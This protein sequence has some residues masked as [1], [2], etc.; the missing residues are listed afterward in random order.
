MCMLMCVGTEM[1]EGERW[2]AHVSWRVRALS[3][4]SIPKK[5]TYEREAK[6]TKETYERE[7]KETYCS[8]KRVN[9]VWGAFVLCVVVGYSRDKRDLR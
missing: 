9:V 7:A 6:E 4:G 1:C 2:G 8:G 3:V 5:E